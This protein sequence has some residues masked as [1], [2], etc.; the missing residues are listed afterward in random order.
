MK[1]NIVIDEN[2]NKGL[3]KMGRGFMLIVIYSINIYWEF[4]QAKE[5]A[6]SCPQ[7]ATSYNLKM[8]PMDLAA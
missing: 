3:E 5:G 4:K 6:G 7:R 2:F 1:F 8:F